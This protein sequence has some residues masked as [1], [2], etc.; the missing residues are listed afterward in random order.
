MNCRG[1]YSLVVLRLLILV[2][3]PCE[4]SNSQER[5]ST[6][7]VNDAQTLV[8]DALPT[9]TKRLPG[10]TLAAGTIESGGRCVTFDVLWRNP[11]PGSTHVNFYTVDLQT[12]AIWSGPRP[13]ARL[14]SGPRVAR[15][16][17][18]LRQ[19]IGLGGKMAQ[20]DVDRSPCWR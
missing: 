18:I 10:L 15:R 12:A 2:C 17:H 6:L 11:G 16:Q 5:R 20:L 1:Q 19:K 14:E 3:G 4:V 8:Y 9:K 7:S 13:P